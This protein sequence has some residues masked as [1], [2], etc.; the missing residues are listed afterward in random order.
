MRGLAR[1]TWLLPV[2]SVGFA[3]YIA[4]VLLG[5]L[6]LHIPV[7]LLIILALPALFQ[8]WIALIVALVDVTERPKDVLS[9]EKQML[10]MLVLALLNVFAFIPYWLFV[11]RRNRRTAL[12]VG[13]PD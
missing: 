2:A 13:D 3:V 7:W 5:V 4:I 1:L 12:P 9:E 11:V 6:V 10:W 8:T